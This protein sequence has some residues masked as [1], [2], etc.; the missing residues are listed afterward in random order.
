MGPRTQ[1]Y[2][3]SSDRHKLSATPPHTGRANPSTFAR[4]DYDERSIPDDIVDTPPDPDPWPHN[5]AGLGLVHAG[6]LQQSGSRNNLLPEMDLG[7]T[8]K[9][10]AMPNFCYESEGEPQKVQKI[11]YSA[12]RQE[13]GNVLKLVIPVR[14]GV[15][16]D[17]LPV[18]TRREIRL[19]PWE[20]G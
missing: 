1:G 15:G 9:F 18:D 20:P 8:P 12:A 7:M 14:T 10:Y 5:P 19:V 3:I 2:D 13:R 11:G 17:L 4:S 6:Q 16:G